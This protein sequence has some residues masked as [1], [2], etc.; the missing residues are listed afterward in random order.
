MSYEFVEHREATLPVNARYFDGFTKD[1]L[2]LVGGQVWCNLEM[3]NPRNLSIVR[4][5]I[6]IGEKDYFFKVVAF[7]P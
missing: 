1:Y 2:W 5:L 3:K 7:H 6:R 4:V